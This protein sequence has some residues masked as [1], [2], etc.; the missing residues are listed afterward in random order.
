M[1]FVAGALIIMLVQWTKQQKVPTQQ[2]PK[3]ELQSQLGVIVPGSELGNPASCNTAMAGSAGST[4]LPSAPATLQKRNSG[5]RK[6][7]KNKKKSPSS[8]RTGKSK[9]SASKNNNYT[10]SESNFNHPAVTAL[11]A[12][13]PGSIDQSE[14]SSAG[15]SV[16]SGEEN[17]NS[18]RNPEGEQDVK[19]V[20]SD[21]GGSVPK[22][23][24]TQAE[25]PNIGIET[26]QILPAENLFVKNSHQDAKVDMATV[27]NTAFWLLMGIMLKVRVCCE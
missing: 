13:E 7:T 2:N 22:S 5:L 8:K 21:I 14:Q 20:D 9:R 27:E 11:R 10:N 18:R 15:S 17:T 3:P 12:K 6:S 4:L 25:I 1:N 23:S 24:S 16:H 26:G 19:M